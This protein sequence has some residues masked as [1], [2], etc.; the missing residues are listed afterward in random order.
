M[1]HTLYRA[2]LLYITQIKMS[3]V[4]FNFPKIFFE[5]HTS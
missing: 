2:L 1:A 4:N 5:S 3:I